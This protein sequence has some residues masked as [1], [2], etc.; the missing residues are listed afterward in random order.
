MPN[1]HE[2]NKFHIRLWFSVSIHTYDYNTFPDEL[3]F[4]FLHLILRSFVFYVYLAVSVYL[5]I[6]V[7][8]KVC[9]TFEADGF[10]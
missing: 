7:G 9:Y 3:G 6:M 5:Y 1:T 10:G 8:N 4:F 2:I